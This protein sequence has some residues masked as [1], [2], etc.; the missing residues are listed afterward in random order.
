MSL[1]I[2]EQLLAQLEPQLDQDRAKYHDEIDIPYIVFDEFLDKDLAQQV[3][4]DFPPIGDSRWDF[5]YHF[6]ERKLGYNIEH[7]LPPSVDSLVKALSSK[8]FVDYLEKLTKIDGLIPDYSHSKAMHYAPSGGFINL[9][10]DPNVHPDDRH[11]KRQVNLLLYLN[12]NW[13]KSF[14]G[15][16]QIWNKPVTKCYAKALPI[17]N[18]CLIFNT[19]KVMH[20]F[21]DPITCPEKDG[22]KAIVMYYF[23]REDKEIRQK[24]TGYKARPSDPLSAKINVF[25]GKVLLRIFYFLRDH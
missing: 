21:P 10:M 15:E 19:M 25:S 2:A 6:N 5:N 24:V 17:L 18:R 4:S 1:D 16:L 7:A 20:G 11:L 14:G 23:T 22:R 9:H 12:E 13:E 3:S 8:A